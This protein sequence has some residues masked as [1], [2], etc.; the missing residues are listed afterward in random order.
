MYHIIS[1]PLEH[2]IYFGNVLW[3]RLIY[4]R[5]TTLR[6]LGFHPSIQ[7]QNLAEKNIDYF[8]TNID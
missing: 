5:Y 3:N 2:G 6:S 7:L 1:T 8:T 4:G